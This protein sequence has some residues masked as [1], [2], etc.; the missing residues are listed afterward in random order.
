MDARD[1]RL[2]G[3]TILV[4]AFVATDRVGSQVTPPRGRHAAVSAVAST[5]PF[6][7]LFPVR[8]LPSDGAL[9]EL[10]AGDL[11]GDGRDEILTLTDGPSVITAWSPEGHGRFRPVEL[12]TPRDDAS[13]VAVGDLDGDGTPDLVVAHPDSGTVAIHPGV[14][15]L[16]FRVPTVLA[17]GDGARAVA[18]DDVDHDGDLDVLTADDVGGT[19]TLLRNAGGGVFDPGVQLPVGASAWDLVV[20]DVTSDGETDVVVSDRAAQQVVLLAGIARPGGPTRSASPS[21]LGQV[22][23]LHAPGTPEAA[24]FASGSFSATHVAVHRWSPA[25]GAL[26]E[27]PVDVSVK[28][29]RSTCS[30]DLDG[31]GAPDL[32]AAGWENS[33]L[34][35]APG[36]PGGTFGAARV[37]P[38]TPVSTGLAIA[39][40]TGSGRPSVVVG[41]GAFFNRMLVAVHAPGADGW[42]RTGTSVVDG[43]GCVTIRAADMTEDGRPDAVVGVW[44]HGLW[45]VG[46]HRATAA[47]S[48]VMTDQVGF[49]A[50]GLAVHDED[51]D[52]HLDVLACAE[53]TANDGVVVVPGLGNGKLD[54]PSFS[55][56]EMDP[57]PSLMAEVDLDGHGPPD[58][59]VGGVYDRQLGALVDAPGPGLEVTWRLATP[60]TFRDLAV[61]DLDGDHLPD[62]IATTGTELL[63]WYEGVGGGRFGDEHRLRIPGAAGTVAAADLD[64]DGHADLVTGASGVDA[65]TVTVL[66]GDGT[67]DFPMRTLLE[68]RGRVRVVAVADLDGDGLPDIV[69]GGLQG[70][71]V[72][73]NLGDRRFGPEER[74]VVRTAEDL[75]VGDADGDG[76]LDL[77]V[78]GFG[79][80][81]VENLTID[82]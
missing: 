9:V 79:A 42:P 13:D 36:L 52:G 73:R 40:V 20:G 43:V 21:S 37:G 65:D 17:A 63:S 58:L 49:R 44:E 3:P 41:G 34:A 53:L 14:G 67:G 47:G 71:A 10:V 55:V 81:V 8:G 31:D 12:A 70:V 50:T 62:V 26:E 82:L 66:W 48:F 22:L 35:V 30:A 16:A 7:A 32:V 57:G 24:V 59:V 2:L 28:G 33:Q 68:D 54:I 29:V 5:A 38:T 69:A 27:T 56:T 23:T 15:G 25:L 18:L 75:V 64:G 11:D 1:A 60:L 72:R 78:A 76:D 80:E 4:L 74:Y 19:V 39:D 77:W 61:A 6:G 46:I 51:G 45:H